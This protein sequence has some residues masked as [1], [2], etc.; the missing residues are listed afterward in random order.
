MNK[1]AVQ[2]TI[3]SSVKS[4]FAI[5]EEQLAKKLN[6]PYPTD[7]REHFSEPLLAENIKK[8]FLEEANLKH[9][10]V[11]IIDVKVKTTRLPE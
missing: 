1:Y 3:I 10:D 7:N 9:P 2:I 8:N 6:I 4:E 11:N 5:T